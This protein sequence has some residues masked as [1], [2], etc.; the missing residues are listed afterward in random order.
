MRR[1]V[2]ARVSSSTPPS[3]TSSSPASRGTPTSAATCCNSPIAPDQALDEGRPQ[4][5]LHSS[6]PEPTCDPAV[7]GAK[8]AFLADGAIE[9]VGR[10]IAG[11][12]DPLRPATP[13]ER[14]ID[15]DRGP[16]PTIFLGPKAHFPNGIIG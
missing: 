7:A 15:A 6:E 12:V 5:R 10:A 13:V 4:A 1:T 11:M 9:S 16:Q 3:S 2:A 8:R 14:E